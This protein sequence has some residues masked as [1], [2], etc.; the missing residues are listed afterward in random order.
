MTGKELLLALV[1]A[2]LVG[3]AAGAAASLAT[4]AKEPSPAENAAQSEV[5]ARLKSAET[6]LAEARAALDASRKSI[7]ELQ[8][9]VTT[10][11]LKAAKQAA[12]GAATAAAAAPHA[13]R[14]FKVVRRGGAADVKGD[15]TRPD[16]EVAQM[17]GSIDVDGLSGDVGVEIGKALEGMGDQLGDIGPQLQEL[18]A[19]L[20]LRK[21]PEDRRWEKAKDDLGLTWNQVEDMKKAVADRDAAMKAATVSEKKTG[22]NGGSITIMR[23]DAGKAAHAEA[24]YHDRV[25]ATLNDEQKKS[26]KSKGYEN[27]FG[28]NGF[29][30]G[31]MV[32]TLGVTT[33]KTIDG[34]KDA[35]K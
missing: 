17:L 3:G 16:D 13:G 1:G 4:A 10:A 22:P 19:G 6:Q 8:E 35:T 32:M 31:G 30:S 18:R 11:E 5:E 21:L 34:A 23:P 14:G 9:R 26:W 28:S 29:G 24:D 25:G 2:G 27:A 33:D 12:D 20:A 7:N 15:A